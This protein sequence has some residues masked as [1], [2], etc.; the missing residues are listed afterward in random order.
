MK[1]LSLVALLVLTACGGGGGGKS[2]PP[3]FNGDGANA[4]GCT[5]EVVAGVLPGVN[6]DCGGGPVFVPFG[7]DGA[8]GDTGDTGTAGTNGINGTNGVDGQDG[9]DG[10]SCTFED[11]PEENRVA[12]DCGGNIIYVPTGDGNSGSNTV[13]H[14]ETI[15]MNYSDYHGRTT[16]YSSGAEWVVRLFNGVGELLSETFRA[17]G[18]NTKT[19]GYKVQI[20]NYN[21]DERLHSDTDEPA[22]VKYSGNETQNYIRHEEWYDNGLLHRSDD[23]AAKIEYVYSAGT[24][25]YVKEW[26]T[27]GINFRAIN[28]PSKVQYNWSDGSVSTAQYRNASGEFH[29]TDGPADATYKSDGTYNRITYYQN[30]LRHRAEG[31]SYHNP[32]YQVSWHCEGVLYKNQNWYNAYNTW[33]NATISNGGLTAYKAAGCLESGWNTSP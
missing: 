2:L 22:V 11:Q 12:I 29:R 5:T 28:S 1:Y 7:V 6:I 27:Q 15:L 23:E 10:V 32:G 13:G 16:I 4:V 25:V 9:E 18:S 3:T 31:Y 24:H 26:Y 19:P 20:N 8:K 30:G 33:K 21:A 14:S 17:R